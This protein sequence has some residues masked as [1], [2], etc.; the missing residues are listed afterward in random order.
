MGLFIWHYLR[1]TEGSFRKLSQREFDAIWEG[2]LPVP[3]DDAGNVRTAYVVG[4]MED[5]KVA[6][7]MRIDFPKYPTLRG[8]L[9]KEAALHRAV[10]TLDEPYNPTRVKFTQRMNNW[11]PTP[12]EARALIE[13]INKRAKRTVLKEAP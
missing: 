12:E 7:I 9:D 11:T 2:D 4:E 3:A 6:R 8:R 10:R 13:L 1:T 5:R